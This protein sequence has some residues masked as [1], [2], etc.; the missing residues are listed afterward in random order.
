[1]VRYA[2]RR[3]SRS[4]GFA[5]VLPRFLVSAACAMVTSRAPFVGMFRG[6]VVVYRRVGQYVDIRKA[7]L[8]NVIVSINRIAVNSLGGQDTGFGKGHVCL[9]PPTR[10]KEYFVSSGVFAETL[11]HGLQCASHP[12]RGRFG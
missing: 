1:M 3:T 5:L 9:C 4:T 7:R 10:A 11:P 2:F 8:C 12:A 6:G